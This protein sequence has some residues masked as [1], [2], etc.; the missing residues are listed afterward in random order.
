MLIEIRLACDV[1]PLVAL[2]AVGGAPAGHRRDA[3]ARSTPTCGA[4]RRC[5][6]GRDGRDQADDLA[7]ALGCDHV[8]HA[9]RF[10]LDRFE[11]SI[12]NAVL[13]RWPITGSRAC[14]RC[15]RPTGLDELRV[16][17][18]ADIDAP[19]GPI[20]VFVDPP[21][22]AASTRATCAGPG[23]AL[24][25]FVAATRDR[26]TFP[27]IVCGDFNAEPESEEIRMLTGLAAVPVP[28]LVFIDAWRG[29]GD[30]PGHDVGTTATGSPPL[31]SSPTGASTTSSSGSPGPTARVTRGR[32]P[33][34]HR[35][36]RRG[37]AVGPLRRRR[38]DP[39]LSGP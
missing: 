26:R 33:R 37:L 19:R 5:S 3:C 8:A 25:E 15:P 23:R 18:R 39:L 9:S 27:P 21:Q 36:G 17:V 13:S 11:Q 6:A 30:G 10:D 29:R 2:R 22:L 4:S 24:C 32:A 14:V 38:R 28:K 35:A 20:E 34:G 12:G 16:V 31:D 1:E 7:A